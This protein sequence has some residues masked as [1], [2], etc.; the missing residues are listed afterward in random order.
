MKKESFCL[1]INNRENSTQNYI[2]EKAT[3]ANLFNNHSI[4]IILRLRGLFSTK[5]PF[6]YDSFSHPKRV[7]LHSV[8]DPLS[9]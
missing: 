5:N 9:T 4:I 6:S 7:L 3:V 2:N 8:T 1:A